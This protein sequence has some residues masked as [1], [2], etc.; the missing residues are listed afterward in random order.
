M[1]E[2]LLYSP[3]SPIQGSCSVINGN[4]LMIL[5]FEVPP[6]PTESKPY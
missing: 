2:I 6:R 1:V 4:K 3:M 5:N